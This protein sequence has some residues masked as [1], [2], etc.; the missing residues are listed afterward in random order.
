MKKKRQGKFS[1]RRVSR[2][3]YAK[4]LDDLSRSISSLEGK[5]A[6][7][8]DV[9]EK[10]GASSGFEQTIQSRAKTEQALET[11]EQLFGSEKQSSM[12]STDR[13]GRIMQKVRGRSRELLSLLINEGFHTYAEISKKMDISESRARAYITELKKNFNIPIKQVRDPEGYKIGLDVSFVD[14]LL[15]AAK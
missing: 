11:S 9:L 14:R 6:K 13:N 1:K 2:R 5:I 12:A 10:I 15:S 8:T 7:L 4:N 3:N